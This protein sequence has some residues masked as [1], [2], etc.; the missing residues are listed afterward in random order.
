MTATLEDPAFGYSDQP[1]TVAQEALMTDQTE[2]RPVPDFPGYRVGSDGSFWTNRKPGPGRQFYAEWKRKSVRPRA[3]GYVWV[4][5]V[6]QGRDYGRP[7][8]RL[9]LEAFVGPRPARMVAC[10]NNGKRSDNR[11]SNLRWDLQSNNLADRKKHQ[12][13]PCQQGEKN[14][15]AKLTAVQ[16][17]TIRRLRS[18][19]MPR[20][21]VARLFGIH[22]VTVSQICLRKR[23]QHL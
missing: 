3:D 9:I 19:G 17:N 22:P 14:H 18:E 20:A 13:V 15:T 16:V 12:T 23:W 5:L 7:L 1:L 10:H 4:S 21:E 8:H 2:Y 6:R 11:L